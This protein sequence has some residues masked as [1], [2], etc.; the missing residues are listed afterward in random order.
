MSAKPSPKARAAPKSAPKAAPSSSSANPAKASV[1][2]A[3]SSSKSPPAGSKCL[4]LDLSTDIPT[5]QQAFTNTLSIAKRPK[6]WA[7]CLTAVSGG[8]ADRHLF[9]IH[10]GGVGNAGPAL[11]KD[12]YSSARRILVK[13]HNVEWLL[14]DL[15]VQTVGALRPGA[16][17]YVRCN[18]N[19]P[20]PKLLEEL[21]KP[22]HGG[23]FF[24]AKTQKFRQALGTEDLVALKDVIEVRIK[25]HSMI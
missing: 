22:V 21:R 17:E 12:I 16:E 7:D 18:W 15:H 10:G 8:G 14:E 1:A 23:R 25:V 20:F 2:A 11:A 5:L 24:D 4:V 6:K 9:P 3:A 19:I 13:N